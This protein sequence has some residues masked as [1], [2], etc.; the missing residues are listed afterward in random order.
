MDRRT[1][2]RGLIAGGTAGLLPGIAAAQGQENY[3]TK[4]IKFIVPYAAGGQPD[5]VA[6]ALTGRLGELLGQAI[7]V[8]NRAGGSGVV[9]Y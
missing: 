8:E 9:A 4:P 3:P 7:I 1:F 2:G 5:S 6:R